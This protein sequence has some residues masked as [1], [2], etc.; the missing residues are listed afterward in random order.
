M[1]A[2]HSYYDLKN[3]LFEDLRENYCQFTEKVK[4]K[5]DIK[6]I[7]VNTEGYKALKESYHNRLDG[8]WEKCN[9]CIKD[10]PNQN[11]I[12]NFVETIR[13]TYVND[14]YDDELDVL[15]SCRHVLLAVSMAQVFSIGLMSNHWDKASLIILLP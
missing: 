8:V 4:T 13:T 2:W 6:T 15:C 5:E 1:E 9:E 12:Q 3:L 11:N 14:M 7:I 10:L